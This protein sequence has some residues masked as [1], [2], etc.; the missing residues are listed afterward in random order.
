MNTL[1]HIYP[2]CNVRNILTAI[3]REKN[4]QGIVAK[5]YSNIK[6]IQVKYLLLFPLKLLEKYV[7]F[8][9]KKSLIKN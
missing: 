4:P 3:A 8:K 6:Q 9:V 7:F 1:S 2:F 5:F